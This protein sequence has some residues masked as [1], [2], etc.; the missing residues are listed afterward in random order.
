MRLFITRESSRYPGLVLSPTAPKD[1]DWS[2]LDGSPICQPDDGIDVS[3]DLL[4]MLGMDLDEGDTVEV[5][6]EPLRPPV[7]TIPE[8]T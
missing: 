6:V 4:V 7:R 1:R 3:D 8:G 2:D 5:S